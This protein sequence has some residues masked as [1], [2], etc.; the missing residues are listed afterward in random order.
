MAPHIFHVGDFLLYV[1]MESEQ[2]TYSNY[3]LFKFTA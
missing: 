1:Q 3:L 2:E